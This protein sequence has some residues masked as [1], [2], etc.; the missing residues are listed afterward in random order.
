MEDTTA[1]KKKKKCRASENRTVHICTVH[2]CTVFVH[3]RAKISSHITTC[4]LQSMS[5]VG[6]ILVETSDTATS[7]SA[8]EVMCEGEVKQQ[9]CPTKTRKLVKFAAL[10]EK[11]TSSS[12]WKFRGRQTNRG[13]V[14]CICFELMTSYINSHTRLA[15]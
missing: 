11:H 5:M 7:S 9:Y 1:T 14:S 2:T 6:T 12:F 4:W 10:P 8:R 3:F 15:S 13:R